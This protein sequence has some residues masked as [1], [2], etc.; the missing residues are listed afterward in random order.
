MVEAM[1]ASAGLAVTG[2]DLGDTAAAMVDGVGAVTAAGVVV[3]INPHGVAAM[4]AGDSRNRISRCISL[5]NKRAAAVRLRM[6][7]LPCS[8]R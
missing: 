2:E 8:A 1:A 4:A 5:V 3:A 7:C 6:A